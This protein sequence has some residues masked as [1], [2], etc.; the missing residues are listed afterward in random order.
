M[1]QIYLILLYSQLG[2]SIVVAVSLLWV[3][4]PYGKFFREGWGATIKTK[5]AWVIMEFPAVAVIGWLY[6]SESGYT[7]LILTLFILIWQSHYLHRTFLYP[8]TLKNGNKPYP[9]S[10]VFM[11]IVFNTINGFINGYYLFHLSGSYPVEWLTDP[12]MISGV[13]IFYTGFIINKRSDKILGSLRKPG[14]TEY[15]IPE[16]GLFKWVSCPNYLGE[17]LEWSGWALLTWS[18]PGLAFALFTTANLLPRA[19]SHHKWYRSQFEQY[20]SSRKALIPF[21]M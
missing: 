15:K 19:L 11:A 18:L 9:L 5:Y 13:V 3:S 12:R 21:I 10:L 2:L 8:F 17:I 1:D 20:P 6:F 16:G 4:A 7:S 14:G